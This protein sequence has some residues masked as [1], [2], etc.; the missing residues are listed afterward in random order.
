LRNIESNFYVILSEEDHIKRDV[1]RSVD[2]QRSRNMQINNP[3]F[4][5]NTQP[6]ENYRLFNDEPSQLGPRRQPEN[7]SRLEED[8]LYKIIFS[9]PLIRDS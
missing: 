5:A 1:Q 4:F 8:R 7:Q 9:M 6:D 3:F 2:A